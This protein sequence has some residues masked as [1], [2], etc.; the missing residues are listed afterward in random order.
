[1]NQTI[2][3][4]IDSSKKK[5]SSAERYKAYA[6]AAKSASKKESEEK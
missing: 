2:M 6:E 3:I 4:D 5:D 1:M